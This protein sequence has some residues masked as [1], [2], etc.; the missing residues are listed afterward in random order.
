MINASDAYGR[1]KP[2]GGAAKQTI[3]PCRR[4]SF[5]KRGILPKNPS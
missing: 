3:A 5:E 4:Y 1:S 2:N